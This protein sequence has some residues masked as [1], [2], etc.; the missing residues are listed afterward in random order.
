VAVSGTDVPFEDVVAQVVEVRV[1]EVTGTFNRNVAVSLAEIEVI[2]RAGTR[3]E[4]SWRPFRF[5]R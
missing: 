2:G 4:V 5:R 1:D 3:P